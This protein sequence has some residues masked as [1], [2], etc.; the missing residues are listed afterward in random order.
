MKLKALSTYAVI[1]AVAVALDQWIKH[2]VETRLVLHEAVEMLPF[3]ALYRTYN[4]GIAFSMFSSFGDTGLILLSLAVIAFVL[5]LAFRT[6]GNQ[7][8]ARLGFTLIIGGALGNLVDRAV[9]GHV[10]DYILFHTPVWSFAVF[11]LADTFITVGAALV[12]LEELLN[13]RRDR[14]AQR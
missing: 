10:I 12:I 13:W 7:V 1:L 9:Y 6:D 8:V 11:N 4:T 3:L 2:L 14:A 5:F